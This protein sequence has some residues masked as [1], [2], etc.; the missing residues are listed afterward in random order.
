MH[1]A[2]PACNRKVAL[3]LPERFVSAL[4]ILLCTAIAPVAA[5][6]LQLSD[7]LSDSTYVEV[8]LG[9]IVEVEPLICQSAS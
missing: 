7:A 4:G 9:E 6:I 3:T 1:L 2:P 8:V 5:Q